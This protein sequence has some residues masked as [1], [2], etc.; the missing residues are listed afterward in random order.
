MKKVI[1]RWLPT[2]IVVIIALFAWQELV[3]FYNEAK[4]K[5]KDNANKGV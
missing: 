2:L 4:A 5:L 3:P 1:L